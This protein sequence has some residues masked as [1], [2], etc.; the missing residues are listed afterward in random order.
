MSYVEDTALELAQMA[1]AEAA[2]SGNG[3]I[4]DDI[5]ETLCASSQSLQEAY[6]TFIR[7]LRA[8]ERARGMLKDAAAKRAAS[9]QKKSV[10]IDDPQNPRI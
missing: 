2:A 9:Q 7:V 3:K 10:N 6:L 1:F 4:V 8:E 5:G